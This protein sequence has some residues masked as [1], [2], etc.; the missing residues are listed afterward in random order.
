MTSQYKNIKRYL[1]G[2]MNY[3]DQCGFESEMR[4]DPFLSDAVDGFKSD[5]GA[6]NDLPVFSQKSF[7]WFYALI[8]SALII[9]FITLDY[10]GEQKDAPTNQTSLMKVEN[11]KK[12]DKI[13][14]ATIIL[15]GDKSIGY[16]RNAARSQDFGSESAQS[17]INSFAPVTLNWMEKRKLKNLNTNIP[18]AD[19][20]IRYEITYISDLKLV[21]SDAWITKT[22]KPDLLQLT[23]HLPAKYESPD[24]KGNDVLE[25]ETI[26]PSFHM[27]WSNVLNA[28]RAGNYPKALFTL[29]EMKEKTTSTDVNVQFYRGLILYEMSRYS[30]AFTFFEMA[31]Y[32]IVPA[33]REEAK[34][35]SA[36]SLA[37]NGDSEKSN[38]LFREIRDAG[39]HYA[40]RAQKR[41]KRNP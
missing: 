26:E 31:Q 14:S 16:P 5:P 37:A 22:H 25:D 29:D 19:I 23:R 32:N 27:M 34:W 2:K 12:M 6:L 9:G 21:K 13:D 39:G 35:Y 40:N 3:S 7:G 17:A 38:K 1:N 33:F 20:K 11:A 10:A 36:L 41:V 8:S 30:E 15:N 28:Y 24:L 18:I 4:D